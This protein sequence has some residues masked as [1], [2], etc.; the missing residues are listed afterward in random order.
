MMVLAECPLRQGASNGSCLLAYRQK[1]DFPSQK[2]V[3][4]KHA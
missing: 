3:S 4:A 2:N 1:S